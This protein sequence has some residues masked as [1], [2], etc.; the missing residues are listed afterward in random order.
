MNTPQPYTF[1][2]S[3]TPLLAMPFVPGQ[4]LPP[5]ASEVHDRLTGVVHG[6]ISIQTEPPVYRKIPPGDWVVYTP[7]G[8][9]TGVVPAHLFDLVFYATAKG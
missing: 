7:D 2:P 3:N 6:M 1:R 4:P 5:V 8:R 9:C